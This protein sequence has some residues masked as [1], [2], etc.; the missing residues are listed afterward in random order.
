[1]A[2]H[3]AARQIELVYGGGGLGLM[4][5]MADAALGKGGRVVGVIPVGLFSREVGHTGLSQLHEVTSMHQRKR[6]MCDFSDGFVALPGG[7][8]TLQ[9]L[10]EVATWTQLG[11]H[12]QSCCSTWTGSGLSKTRTTEAGEKVTG[13]TQPSSEGIGTRYEALP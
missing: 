3:V 9:E 6:L 7:L 11:L 13:R 10:A 2:W 5:A 8:G 1:M 4:G 12:N